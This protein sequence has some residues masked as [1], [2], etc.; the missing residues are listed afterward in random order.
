MSGKLLRGT[1]SLLVTVAIANPVPV[2]AAAAAVQRDPCGAD[3]T[4]RRSQDS[5]GVAE[6]SSSD[7]EQNHSKANCAKDIKRNPKTGAP[8][9]PNEGGP[10]S[11]PMKTLTF[12]SM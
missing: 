5:A 6:R 3:D 9:A 11:P 1:F 2:F 10:S 12:P 7:L 4:A 8:L